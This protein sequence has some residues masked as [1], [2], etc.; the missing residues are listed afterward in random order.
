MQFSTFPMMMVVTGRL[1][2]FTIKCTSK[3][4][5]EKFVLKLSQISINGCSKNI[6]LSAVYLLCNLD[7][8]KMQHIHIIHIDKI[9]NSC[10]HKIMDAWRF[11]EV[12]VP[13]IYVNT[14]QLFPVQIA[15]K[16]KQNNS[17]KSQKH[18]SKALE[19]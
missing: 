11:R 3:F 1:L 15:T 19:L 18:F 7:R 8:K 17:E 10:F 6:L 12:P 16:Q 2:S 9:I 4:G 13:G 14:R 5:G